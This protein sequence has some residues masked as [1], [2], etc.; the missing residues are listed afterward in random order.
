[1]KILQ[2]NNRRSIPKQKF[3]SCLQVLSGHT[4]GINALAWYPNPQEPMLVSGSSDG[5]VKLWFFKED[6][7]RKANFSDTIM[8][9]QNYYEKTKKFCRKIYKF[10]RFLFIIYNKRIFNKTKIL[11]IKLNIF[12]VMT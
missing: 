2:L 8:L 9:W 10:R 1:M 6:T 3:F 5:T 4:N 7:T 12:Y 11:R